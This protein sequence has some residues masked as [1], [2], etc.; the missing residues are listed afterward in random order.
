MY[1]YIDY[2]YYKYIFYCLFTT[3]AKFLLLS[4]HDVKWR[5]E[6]R[7]EMRYRLS[8]GHVTDSMIKGPLSSDGRAIISNNIAKVC[9]SSPKVDIYRLLTDI[10]CLWGGVEG[11]W[12]RSLREIAARLVGGK[13]RRPHE[14][15]SIP[16]LFT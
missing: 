10:Y 16:F 4:V 3:V 1:T 7:R 13:D 11:Q 6:K 2:T 9:L 12:V 5:E 8:L 14:T 15:K